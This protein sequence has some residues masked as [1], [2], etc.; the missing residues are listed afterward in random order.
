MMLVVA[1]AFEELGLLRDYV[2]FS[3]TSQI[4]KMSR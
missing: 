2:S 3:A 4:T 1:H